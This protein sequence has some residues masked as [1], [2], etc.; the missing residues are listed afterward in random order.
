MIWISFLWKSEGYFHIVLS[1]LIVKDSTTKELL[2]KSNVSRI[3][4]GSGCQAIWLPCLATL[5][6]CSWKHLEFYS[7]IRKTLCFQCCKILVLS[8]SQFLLA[9]VLTTC[10]GLLLDV[11][12]VS[13]WHFTFCNYCICKRLIILFLVHPFVAGK[14]IIH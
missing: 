13:F 2:S 14:L 9:A 6:M 7:F 10:I 4:W 11:I 5:C 12:C 1:K 3:C 8:C